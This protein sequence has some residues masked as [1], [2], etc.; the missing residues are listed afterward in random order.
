MTAPTVESLIRDLAQDNVSGAAEL[1]RDAAQVFALLAKESEAKDLGSFLR[2]LSATGREVV[3]AQPSMAPLFNLVNGVLFDLD[4]VA[5]LE[6]ARRRAKASAQGFAEE[7][8]SRGQRI[9]EEALTVLSH[10]CTVLTHS[11][12]ST[13]LAALLLARDRGVEFEV[14]CT[15]S[16]PLYEGRK[17]AEV[18]SEAGIH[19]TLV[20]D[21]SV[22]HI[23]PRADLVMV[24]ADSVS[25]EGLVNKMGTWGVALAAKA[26]GVPLY[27]L[28]GTEK[29][30]PG[31]YPYFEI[32]ARDPEEV[33]P[34][35]PPA[36]EVLNYYFEVTPLEYV[37]GLITER[38][39]LTQAK[40]GEMLGGLRI[41]EML[42]GQET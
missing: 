6:E 41:H 2:E 24:G 31:G 28:C 16:R 33:W 13:V 36:V 3:Q 7:L 8:E 42:L 15:E 26:H 29:L 25:E 17:V 35:F 21:A 20:T 37:S 23:L 11:R 14:V 5:S 39:R 40:V 32:E 22:S 34:G 4:G 27:A 1:A 18:L 12:S 30:L 19:T 9:A 38:G 10:G